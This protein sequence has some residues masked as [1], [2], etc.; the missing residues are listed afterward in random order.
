[1]HEERHRWVKV[2]EH[3]YICRKCGCGRVNT[4][5]SRGEWFT[6]FHRPDGRSVVDSHVPLC[7]PGPRTAAALRKYEAAIAIAL[8]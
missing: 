4:Q 3:V 5:T 7:Q 2:R 1:M 8:A 6:T